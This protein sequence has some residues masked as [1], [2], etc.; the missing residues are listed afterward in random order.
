MPVI[1]ILLGVG[2]GLLV[3]SRVTAAHDA[4]ERFSR[5]RNESS[6]SRGT[7]LKSAVTAAIT[8]TIVILLL[9][10]FAVRT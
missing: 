8:V 4:H 10:A 1:I 9:Y 6:S 7:W 5:Y 2:A 3:G